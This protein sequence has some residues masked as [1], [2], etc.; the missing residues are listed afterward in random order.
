MASLASTADSD[1]E[2]TVEVSIDE[3]TQLD[4]RPSLLQYDDVNPGELVQ[5]S[6]NDHGFEHLDVENIGSER[7]GEI[8]VEATKP[9]DQP[10]GAEI[11]DE[12]YDTGN[13]L[14]LGLDTASDLESVN[15][16]IASAVDEDDSF[17]GQPP[18]YANRVDF[19]E[20]NFP[21]YINPDTDDDRVIGRMR[22]GDVEYFVE[23]QFDPTDPEAVREIRI[24]RAPHTATQLGTTD[25][26]DD[27]EV[28]VISDAEIESDSDEYDFMSGELQ[29][30]SF[31]S[32]DDDYEGE[33]LIEI[34]ADGD[35][36][37]VDEDVTLSDYD[38][39]KVTEYSL[40]IHPE[41]DNADEPH[42]LRTR[43][44]E[45]I[46]SP[47]EEN[48]DD[49]QTI[50]SV[51]DGQDQVFQSDTAGN[52]LQPGENFPVDVSVELPQGVDREAIEDGTIT[53]FATT[54][55]SE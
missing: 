23:V 19:F 11:D 24:G 28:V 47:G 32:D 13:F 31:D 29:L 3:T 6:D 18:H 22:E 30:V 4:V 2:S 15:D 55:D 54:G 8:T 43:F 36:T 52:Q 7:I 27:D 45:D 48:E 12:L 49:G 39:S 25:F 26:S 50:S 21:E 1:Q 17:D 46:D 5:V 53:F 10:F 20:D 37:T 9:A 14:Q 44:G 34:N 51:A 41:D 38:R 35:G 33:N 16:E 40:F 42:T